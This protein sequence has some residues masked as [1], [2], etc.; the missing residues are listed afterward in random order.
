MRHTLPDQPTISDLILEAEGRLAMGLHPERARR[1]AELLLVH[2][3]QQAN[4]EHNRATLIAHGNEA[5]FHR[6][7]TRYGELVA[8][9]LAGEPIQYITGECEFFGLPFKVTCDVLI[10][11]PE[12]EH[13]VE[14]AI[15]LAGRFN[16]PRIVDVGTGS[17]AI[18]VA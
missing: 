12:T 9:R 18:V 13:L 5:L 1:D 4:P 2:I 11:R 8:R 16:R 17:G 14:K 6:A 15:E 3:V 10:P 7:R